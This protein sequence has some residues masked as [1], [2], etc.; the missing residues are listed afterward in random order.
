MLKTQKASLGTAIKAK[1]V[2]ISLVNVTETVI[3]ASFFLFL[4]YNLPS[5]FG[6]AAKMILANIV[7]AKG[8]VI[9]FVFDK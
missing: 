4:Q 9:H 7:K 3:D 6:Q 1:I 8:N 2:T 5:T